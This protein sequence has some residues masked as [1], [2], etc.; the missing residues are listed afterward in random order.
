MSIEGYGGSEKLR[1]MGGQKNTIEGY[2]G[3]KNTD[4]EGYGGPKN[5]AF[6]ESSLLWDMGDLKNTDFQE[7]SVLRGMGVRKTL[8]FRSLA[9]Y[10]THLDFIPEIS[11]DT[12]TAYRGTNLP[13]I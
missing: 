4:F 6:Q 8:I 11:T 2:G 3:P 10:V 13:E 9:Y 1:G 7:S 5:T 12:N